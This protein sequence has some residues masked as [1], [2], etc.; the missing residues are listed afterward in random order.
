MSNVESLAPKRALVKNDNRGLTLDDLV[1]IVKND[2]DH[3]GATG[4]IIIP[5]LQEENT[6]MTVGASFRSNLNHPELAY[7]LQVTLARLIDKAV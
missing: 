3:Q 6:T 1:Q 4:Y 7:A 2:P 5:V